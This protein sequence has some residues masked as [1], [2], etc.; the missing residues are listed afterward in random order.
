[1]KPL[2]ASDVSWFRDLTKQYY[3]QLDSLK[4]DYENCISGQ[5]AGFLDMTILASEFARHEQQGDHRD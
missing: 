2:A 5:R 3:L 1:M 4:N